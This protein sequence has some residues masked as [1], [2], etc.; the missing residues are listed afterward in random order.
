MKDN[1]ADEDKT[2]KAGGEGQ[3]G[4]AEGVTR[5]WPRDAGGKGAKRPHGPTVAVAKGLM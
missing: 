1:N 2:A 3:V 4:L 5:T